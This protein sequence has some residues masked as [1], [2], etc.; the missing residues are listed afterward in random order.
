MKRFITKRGFIIWINNEID[1]TISKKI[2]KWRKKWYKT[3]EI[4]QSNLLTS[5]LSK[6]SDELLKKESVPSGK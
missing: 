6:T 3:V 5:T 2:V 1:Y 4:R